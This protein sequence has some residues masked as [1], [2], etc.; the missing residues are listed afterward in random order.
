MKHPYFRNVHTSWNL[1]FLLLLVMALAGC[2]DEATQKLANALL[3]LDANNAQETAST[4]LKMAEAA[5]DG[6]DVLDAVVGT[7]NVNETVNCN[8]PALDPTN[9]SGS[10]AVSGTDNSTGKDLTITFTDCV[11]RGFTYNGSLHVV[12]STS[13]NVKSGTTTG[14][15]TIGFNGA[16]FTVSNYSVAFTKD[17]V[18]NDY[19]NDFG[20][21]ISSS[22]LSGAGIDVST[23]VPFAGNKLN[24]PDNPTVGE[25]VVTGSGNTKVKV[26]ANDITT[27]TID[28][29]T[30]GDNVYDTQVTNPADG[31]LLFP[32]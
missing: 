12:S 20:M 10:A 22:V 8:D 9:G 23:T 32:W 26:T 7:G 15:L 27:Y 5:D 11:M 21:T 25:M 1:I 2:L 19:T 31:T 13:N 18:T 16:S 28:V 17:Q 6:D 30:D 24:N 3:K 14:D 4:A 29:D